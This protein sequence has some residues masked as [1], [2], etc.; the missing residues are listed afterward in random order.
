ML[1][2][3]TSWKMN[4]TRPQAVAWVNEVIAGLP[5]TSYKQCQIFVIPPYTAIQ[6]VREAITDHPVMVGAQNVHEHPHG[7][8]TG[9]ISA[10]MLAELGCEL[11]EIGH[12]ERRQLYNGDR[13]ASK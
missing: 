4:K 2:V 13:C 11:V 3:G 7:P 12:S 1:L 8:F 6:S 10:P 5:D 9:E